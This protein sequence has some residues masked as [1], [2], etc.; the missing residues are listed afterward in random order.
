MELMRFLGRGWMILGCLM[1]AV[2]MAGCTTSSDE[3]GKDAFGYDPLKGQDPTPQMVSGGPVSTGAANSPSSTVTNAFRVGDVVIV[4]YSD[5]VM[6]VKPSQVTIKPDGTITLMWNETFMAA[7]R[8]PAELQEDIRNRYVP[9]Y[10]KTLTVTVSA[11]DRFFTVSGEVR[12]PNRYVYTGHMTV[13]EAIATAGGFTDFSK[14]TKV[15]VTRGSDNK[16]T[17]V[18]CKKALTHPE[19]NLEIVPGD[20][21]HVKKRI[22][23]E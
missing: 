7:G 6:E 22:L 5:T 13:L 9:K 4:T 17:F 8:I 15:Q 1:V 19:L 16:Q 20:I 3:G 10:Y 23:F 11:A 12:V 21:V 14:K 2:V 18:D